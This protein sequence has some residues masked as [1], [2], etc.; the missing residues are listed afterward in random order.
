VCD[1]DLNISIGADNYAVV[2]ATDIDEGSNDNCGE[3]TLEVRVDEGPW[4]EFVEFDCDDIGTFVTIELRVT[5]ASGNTNTCWLETEVED[6]IT[7]ICYAPENESRHCD[8]EE[9]LHIDWDNADDLNEAFGAPWAEDNCNAIAEQISVNNN[10][11]DCGWGTV[12]R[13]FR[14]V[15]DWGNVSTSQCQQVITVY[16]VHNYEIKFPKDVSAECGIPNPDTIAYNSL[17]CDLITVN[18]VDETYEAESDECY[19]IL[20]TYK[21]INWCE[22]DGESDPIIIGRDEDCDNN[23]GDED[24]WVIVRTEW[25]DNNPEFTA[26][27]DRDNAENNTNPFIGTSRCTPL[28]KPNGH[29]ANSGINVELTSVGHWQYTQVIKV[30][31]FVA[32]TAV[33]D[34]YDVFC[35]ETSDCNGDVSI[36]FTVEE[37]CDLDVVSVEGFIDAYNT[38]ILEAATITGPVAGDDTHQSYTISGNYPI[39]SHSFGVHIE[40]GCNNITWLEIPFEVVDCKA[41]TPVCIDGLTV[42]LMPQPN[43]CCTM[44][45]WATDFIASDIEDCTEPITYSIHRLDDVVDGSDIPSPDQSGIVLDCYDEEITLIRIYS[46]DSAYNPYAM[47]PDGTIGGPNYDFCE[48][49]VL[50]QENESCIPVAASLI[51]GVI[52]TEESEGVENVEVNLSGDTTM[53]QN[54]EQAG[55]YEFDVVQNGYDYTVTPF[56]DE[57]PLNGVTTF[58]LVLITKHI[59][60]VQ[61]IDSPYKLIA[62]DANS[63]G[64]ITT[65][66]VIQIRKLILGIYVDYPSNT[67]WRFVDADYVFPDPTNPW[68][69]EFP[70][71]RNINN[72]S[73]DMLEENFI[74]AKIGDVNGSVIPNLTV[75]EE[76]NVNGLFAITTQDQRV[77]KGNE[78]SVSF[79]AADLDKIQGYQFTLNFDKSALTFKDIEY[80]VT[81][82]QN[83]GLRYL[84]E[85]MITTSWNLP[86]GSTGS[87]FADNATLFTIVF[88]ARTN[89]MLSDLITLNSRVTRAEA[90]DGNNEMLDVA[91]NFTG[92]API[93][94]F[95]VYQNTP[96]PFNSKT[97]IGYSLPEDAT[98]EISIMD[99]T[100]KTLKVIRQDGN[101][102]YNA[103]TL[104]AKTLGVTGVFYY[105]VA[106]DKYTATKKMVV[107]E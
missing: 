66:D 10:L 77:E 63:S 14:A 33:V 73:A 18:V 58:D 20:R 32:P 88:T 98:V 92:L 7:P 61:T 64:S 93:A 57:N 1:D 83:F 31:D 71:F 40:D 48:T 80:G 29:W 25:N 47:Q 38:G 41:P 91:I 60:G 44:A 55:M 97:S 3:I 4:S 24:V 94:K 39:G 27:V 8:D 35:S 50:V 21:V 107:V 76:R 62:A 28:P 85:G 26:Y 74:G 36:T 54:T 53:I 43:G 30:Y 56:L 89:A 84:E 46:W 13:T 15:D 100:G 12:I 42:T 67:S 22:W 69:E 79:T 23:P 6:K 11:N 9:L 49:Y 59:L 75:V 103:V 104:D 102:G 82:A 34:D 2:Y 78:Y 70:E 65:A 106:T 51:A 87:E 96:N 99:L 101:Q 86:G 90:Y 68:F 72:L 17:G 19:K 52:T 81:S 95:E 45:I 37:I 16:E 105:T 5:D